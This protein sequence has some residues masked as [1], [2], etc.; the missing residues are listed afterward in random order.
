M[1]HPA[2]MKRPAPALARSLA[3]KDKQSV[4][5]IC[6]TRREHMAADA[7]KTRSFTEGLRFPRPRVSVTISQARLLRDSSTSLAGQGTGVDD[8]FE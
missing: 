6:I 7:L 1:R 8:P 5:A 4:R 2:V 3:I